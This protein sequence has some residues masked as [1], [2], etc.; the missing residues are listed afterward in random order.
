MSTTYVVVQ[1]NEAKATLSN[2]VVYIVFLLQSQKY[3]TP[4]AQVR[5]REIS[6]LKKERWDG[7]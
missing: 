4:I 2:V 3:L 6:F 5:Q 7:G 1:I